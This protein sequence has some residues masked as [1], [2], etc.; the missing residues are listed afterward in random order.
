MHLFAVGISH[1]TAPV[2]SARV[3]STSRAAACDPRWRRWPRAASAREA[4]VLSTCNRAEIYAVGDTDAAAEAVR[5]L[6]QRVSQRRRT[7]T[8]WRRTCIVPRG[9]EAARHLFRVAAGLDSLVVGE[10]QIL[11]QVKE[12][13]AHRDRAASPPARCRT[14]CSTPRSRVGKRVRTETGLGEGAVS[15]S[16]AAVA[17]AQEDLRRPDA[18]GAC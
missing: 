18:A 5:P 8:R 15:V 13:Y 16:Y 1:R 10:P 17:L 9:A 14:G 7:R 6:H 2:E 12:A 11:G 3:A 4:V